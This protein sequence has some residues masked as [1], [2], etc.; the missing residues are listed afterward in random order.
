VDIVSEK[1]ICAREKSTCSLQIFTY[2]ERKELRIP[3]TSDKKTQ[4]IYLLK[5]FRHRQDVT[6]TEFDKIEM[7]SFTFTYNGSKIRFGIRA[8]GISGKFHNMTLYYYYCDET[9]RNGV[10]LPRTIAPANGT[11]RL[12]L[13]CTSNAVSKENESSFERS[14]RYNGTWVFPANDSGCLCR[15]G[16]E[17]L[18]IGCQR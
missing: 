1:D 11:K 14:C 16:Y 7:Q 6:F 15:P 3:F 9:V 10:R 4:Q 5:N 2:N 17:M 8:R 13:N 12:T 18:K